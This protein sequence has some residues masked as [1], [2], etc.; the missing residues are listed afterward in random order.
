MHNR[1]GKTKG[2][3]WQVLLAAGILIFAAALSGCGNSNPQTATLELESNPTTGYSWRVEQNPEIFDI[4]TD[5]VENSSDTEAVG[6]GGAETFI[7]TPKEEGE[8]EVAFYYERSWEEDTPAT[9]LTYNITV[10]KNKQ[11]KVNSQKGE[12]PDLGSGAPSLPEMVIR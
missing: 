10:D 3:S 12:L 1:K 2:F 4:E 6:V 11:I 7:L 9:V 8:T 5:Y